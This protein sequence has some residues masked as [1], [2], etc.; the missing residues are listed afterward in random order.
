MSDAQ[1]SRTILGCAFKVHT[2]LGSGLLEKVYHTCLMHE[3]DKRG[4]YLE[5]QKSIDI[6]YED[7]VIHNAFRADIIVE[8]R[9]LLELKVTNDIPENHIA[10]VLTYLKF[11]G[12]KY[13]LILNF[14][15]RSLKNGIKRI[16]L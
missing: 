3:L 5:S 10:Q 7:F 16:A 8:E 15:E 11:S 9:Y 13:G 12:F 1:L 14:M 2:A 6:R 4:L